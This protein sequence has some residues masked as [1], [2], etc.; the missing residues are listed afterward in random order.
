MNE[1]FKWV[2]AAIA[3]VGASVGAVVYFGQRDK[4]PP[5][6]P[7]VTEAPLPPAPEG[8]AIKHPVPE[9]ATPE[10]L[11]ALADSDQPVQKALTDLFGQ[12][13]VQKFVIPE[14][15]IRHFV[16]TVDNL[17]EQKVA[18]RLRPVQPVPG[19]FAVSGTE[20][21]PVLDPSNYSRYAPLMQL[22]RDTDTQRLVA[23]YTRYYPLFQDAYANLG[24]P[25]QYFNDRMIEVIDHLLATPEPPGPIA[26][27]RP[28]VLY[29]YADPDIEALSAGQ[30]LLIRMGP[31]NARGV[32][33]KLRELRKAL[34][35]AP[36]EPPPASEKAP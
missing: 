5:P 20:D 19:M 15:L 24:H 4:A 35:S 17:P 13:S 12:D 16:V 27:K 29:E 23:T 9:P 3:V 6:K 32:K 21:Q 2:A 36:Q 7:V 18:Q 1:N 14:E 34:V 30:K 10:R 26:L 25:P 11:P 22:V 28:G 33:D 8:P 31:Q